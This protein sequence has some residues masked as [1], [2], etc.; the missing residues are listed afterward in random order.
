MALSAATIFEINASATANSTNSGGFNPANANMLTNLAADTNTGNTDSPVVS[1]ASYN[2]AAGDVGHWLYIKAGTNWIPGW[3]KIASVA[4]N[5]ATLQAAVGEAVLSDSTLGIPNPY[6]KQ[7]TTA[8]CATVATPTGGTFTID[9]SQTTGAYIDARADFGSLASST[10]I[11]SAT[12]GFHPAMVG[13]LLHLNTTGTGGFGV[14]GWYEIV[15]YTDANNLVL[16]RTP[17]NGTASVACTGSIGGALMLNCTLADDIFELSVASSTIS[18]RFFIKS[19]THVLGESVGPSVNGHANCPIIVE[20]YNSLRGDTPTGD[21]RPLIDASTYSWGTGIH[22]QWFNLR[23]TRTAQPGAEGTN[24][25]AKNCKFVNNSTTANRYA[26]LLGTLSTLDLCEIISYRGYG[27]SASTTST[28]IFILNSY[29]HDSNYALHGTGSSVVYV[30]INSIIANNVTG[31]YICTGDASLR[32]LHGNIFYGSESKIGTAISNTNSGNPGL[33]CANNIFYGFSTVF[34]LGLN[35]QFFDKCNDFY[36]NTTIYGGSTFGGLGNVTDNPA[37]KNVAEITGSTA[38][39]S[40]SVLTQSG[41]DFSA[42][43]DNVDFCHIKSGTGV[44][45]GKYLITSHTTTTLTLDIAPGTNATA[46]KIFS[47]TTGHDFSP[48]YL[49]KRNVCTENIPGLSFS[50]PKYPTNFLPPAVE[51]MASYNLGV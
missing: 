3:Y 8:G 5:K 2:F 13:N 30:I 29:L 6:F 11:T 12:G 16:D 35:A 31:A 39:T 24:F 46:D 36:N 22:W 51:A 44:T 42:V 40:G 7:N 41:A 19:G 17:N 15:N 21:T 27:C 34:N 33:Y 10:T 37:F 20:G 38:T 50:N 25:I 45:A 43:T 23:V 47:V 18:T 26:I 32:V 28:I 49:L 4:S 9:Y 48:G 1:S 14:V